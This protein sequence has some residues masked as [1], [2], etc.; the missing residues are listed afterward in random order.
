[1]AQGLEERGDGL[2]LGRMVPL[3]SLDGAALVEPGLEFLDRS[4]GA[5]G[6]PGAKF[7]GCFFLGVL[8][9]AGEDL[10]AAFAPDAGIP[11]DDF[12][13][14]DFGRGQVLAQPAVIDSLVD[15][16]GDQVGHH[17]GGAFGHPEF[18]EEP[19]GRFELLGDGQLAAEIGA[20]FGVRT[21]PARRG[22]VGVRL[23]LNAEDW[24]QAGMV[25]G[26]GEAID[27]EDR[28]GIAG[29]VLGLVAGEGE[30]VFGG[31]H[32]VDSLCLGRGRLM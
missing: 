12:G 10:G 13:R 3:G 18:F 9:V 32:R 20:N 14:L 1:M 8:F 19:G 16:R 4:M 17:F 23:P 24:V 7:A 6:D 30:E 25:I 22:L 11:G 15:A 5:F 29:A 26:S 21:I 27:C 2:H 31:F 28:M